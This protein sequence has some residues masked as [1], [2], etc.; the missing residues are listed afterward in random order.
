MLHYLH[1]TAMDARL[2][3]ERIQ[4]ATRDAGGRRRRRDPDFL[5]PA[6]SDLTAQLRMVARMIA[7]QLPTRVY[8]VSMGGFD[9]HANQANSHANLMG[10]LGDALASFMADLRESGHDRRVLTMTFSEFGRRVEQN[11]SGGT[12]H[13]AA[14][15]MFLIGSPVRAGLHGDHPSLTDLERGDLKWAI[16]FRRVYAAVLSNWMKADAVRVLGGRFDPLD[17]IK[18]G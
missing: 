4:A 15:Q 6:N 7:A 2:S 8:Y 10:K 9:T 18:A 5:R 3:A 16:D 17:L 13:G 12:D 11:A 1:R 14:S